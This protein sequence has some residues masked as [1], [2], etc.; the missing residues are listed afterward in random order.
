M[1]L[2]PYIFKTADYGKSWSKIVNGFD[3]EHT[4]VRTV[5]EDP[6]RKGLLYAGTETGLYISFNDGRHWQ[7]LQLNL[8]VVP[9]NDL[10]IQSNDLV[11]ATAGRSFWILD[12]LS[13]LQQF[14]ASNE[15]FKLYKPQDTY[16][17]FGGSTE[18]PIPGLGSNPKSGVVID[19]Y[20]PSS[21]DSLDLK[22]EILQDGEVIRTV[23]NNKP[24]DFKSWQG[25]PPKPVVLPSSEG[26]QRFTW[27]F[28]RDEL[29]AVDNVFVFGD[30]Q[31]SR[32]APG[33]Y[34]IRLSLEGEMLEESVQ[35]LTNPNMGD[36]IK[37]YAE[38]Q[39]MLEDLA[40]M[41]EEIHNS[42]NQMRSARKQLSGYKTLLSDN[43]S[44]VDL[45]KLGDSLIERIDTWERNLIQPDQKTF[46]D[47]INYNNQLN[48]EIMYLRGFIDN[49]DPEL[50]QGARERFKDLASDWRVY[51]NERD[52]IVKNEMA[53]YNSKFKD[54]NLPAIILEE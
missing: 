44:A 40:G 52:A 11:A 24:K 18:K 53:A 15:E 10:I 9:I 47:V 45:L 17:L 48:A 2:K 27:D 37:E 36:K 34:S 43:E 3:D 21:A 12:D 29:P 54:L 30:Y 31:G 14:D 8:P 39:N 13:P 23:T 32:V 28:R 1:D 42:V 22:L 6:V 41:I 35:I 25:G 33:T 50:T 46:Q 51:S 20:L 38:Q 7:R 26:H 5:R 49:A 4:F 16:L 19:Y